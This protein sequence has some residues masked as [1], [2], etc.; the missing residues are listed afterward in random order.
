MT[1][2]GQASLYEGLGAP[3]DE[4]AAAAPLRAG[5]GPAEDH[6]PWPGRPRASLH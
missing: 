3:R 2:S 5:L 1:T 6:H 4:A